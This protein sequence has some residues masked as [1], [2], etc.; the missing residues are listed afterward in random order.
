MERGRV[1]LPD[2]WEL[3]AFFET[4]PDPTDQDEAEFFGSVTFTR[5]VG[6]GEVLRWSASVTFADMRVSIL[7]D[8]IERVALVARD[9]ALIGI[10][11]LHD[12][13]TLVAVYGHHPDVQRARLTIRPTF[14]I[15]WGLET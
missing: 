1:E 12:T 5:D 11:R 8:G 2:E 6:G 9:V 3:I 14:R 4:D 15:D 13:E 7:R 10:E